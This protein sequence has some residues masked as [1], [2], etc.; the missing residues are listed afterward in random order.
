MYYNKR[1]V[2]EDYKDRLLVE[3]NKD[4]TFNSR[5]GFNHLNPILE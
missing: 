3:V 4:S 5:I 1:S 2:L